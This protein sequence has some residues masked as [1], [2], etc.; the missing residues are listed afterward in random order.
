MPSRWP[1]RPAGIHHHPDAAHWFEPSVTK[2]GFRKGQYLCPCLYDF[3]HALAG[4]LDRATVD[5]AIA[6]PTP[7]ARAE[8]FA[9][10]AIRDY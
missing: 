3:I 1:S 9:G 5:R 2:I 4:H 10:M 7:E 6:A 8:L